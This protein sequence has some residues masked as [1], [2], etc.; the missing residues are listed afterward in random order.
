[1]K[2]P[3]HSNVRSWNPGSCRRNMYF[4]HSGIFDQRLIP[5][6]P[7][8]AISP[9]ET[10][11]STTMVIRPSSTSGSGRPSGGGTMFGSYDL[12]GPSLLR[13]RW[14]QD[15]TIVYQRV[16]GCRRNFRWIFKFVRV[17]DFALERGH[18]S[19]CRRAE[20]DLIPLRPAPA[21]EVAVEG[22]DRRYASRGS[23][24]DPDAG[25]A[26]GLEH[27]C[28][29]GDEV[30][31]DSALRDSI[32]NLTRA[33]RHRHLYAGVYYVLPENGR[34]G[35]EILVGGVHRGANAHLDRLRTGNFTDRHDVAG[36]GGFRDQR[37]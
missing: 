19:R 37:L 21:R 9:V 8:G 15:L 33:W 36:R 29:R 3:P 31:V 7:S 18:R 2:P 10:S 11:S 23:L 14:V 30:L 22:P 16:G 5:R 27:P 17:G 1:M 6:A 25:S 35:S 26:D 24:P 4:A 12:D 32:E 28:A 13:W 34:S 20:V